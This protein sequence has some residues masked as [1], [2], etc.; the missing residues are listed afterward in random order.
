M[1]KKLSLNELKNLIIYGSQYGTAK[2]YA[3]KLS[4]ITE[5]PCVSYEN[6]KDIR[7]YSDVS[8]LLLLEDLERK[9]RNADEFMECIA[10]YCKKN[11]LDLEVL[12]YGIPAKVKMGDELYEVKLVEYCSLSNGIVSALEFRLTEE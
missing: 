2:A 9:P 11:A 4:E 3:T 5:I 10:S 12:Q 1:V 7:N 6:I 8:V